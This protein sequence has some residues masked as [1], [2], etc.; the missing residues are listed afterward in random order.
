[1][2]VGGLLLWDCFLGLGQRNTSEEVKFLLVHQSLLNSLHIKANI[3][4]MQNYT[5][6]NTVDCDQPIYLLIQAHN[7]PAE[8]S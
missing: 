7:T 3:C 6:Q 1:M 4:L 2:Y 8:N 5:L